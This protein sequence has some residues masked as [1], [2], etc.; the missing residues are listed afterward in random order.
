MDDVFAQ[1]VVAGGYED[2]RSRQLEAAVG[3]RFRARFEQSEIGAAV[4][5][6]QVHRA[7]PATLDEFRDIGLFLGVRS[8][9]G[10][11][12]NRALCQSD[13]HRERHVRGNHVFLERVRDHMRQ[14]LTAIGRVCGQS[15]PGTC[16]K[17]VIGFLESR[18]GRHR[19]I[20]VARAAMFV[21]Y[22]VQRLGNL[23]DEFRAFSEDCTDEIRGGLTK[24]RQVGVLLQSDN[25]IQDKFSV[26]DRGFIDRHGYRCSL[27]PVRSPLFGQ[28]LHSDMLS[29]RRRSLCGVRLIP[30]A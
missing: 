15:A 20:F 7:A 27:V 18:R 9:R 5:L 2:L 13:V 17:C 24:A 23:L 29:K 25:F 1:I 30:P 22:L 10:D 19:A 3:L 26:R 6:C 11:S 16:D 8:N 21:A 28:G 12:G 4:R 14:A